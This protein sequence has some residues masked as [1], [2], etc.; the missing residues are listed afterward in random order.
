MDRMN[1]YHGDCLEV[2]PTL[3]PASVDAIITDLPYG[4]TACDWDSIIPLAP[5]WEQVKRVLKPTGIFI[6][7]ASQPFTSNLIMSNIEMFKHCWYWEK[8]KGA[9]FSAS[10]FQPLKIIE[11]IVLFS[12]GAITFTNGAG[13]NITFNPQKGELKKPYTRDHSKNKSDDFLKTKSGTAFLRKQ[14]FEKIEYTASHPRN[15]LYASTDGDGRVHPTQKPVAIY[16]YLIRT[17][18]NPDEVVLDI[19]MGSGTT[20]VAAVKTGRSFIG[21][22]KEQKYFE[23]ASR[24]I[25]QAPQPLFVESSYCEPA[26]DKALLTLE[27]F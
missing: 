4:T 27:G 25:A 8:S 18:T 5:M 15:L 14:N 1:I 9:N 13:G 23:L 21:I 2:M 7:T 12:N 19:A 24:R 6:T 20:G 22:E 17:Y 10:S 3:P 11:D 26:K 16:E